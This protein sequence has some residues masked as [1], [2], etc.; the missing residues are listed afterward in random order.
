MSLRR[1][2]AAAA[3]VVAVAA[4]YWPVRGYPFVNFDD[5]I[6]VYE[7]PHVLGGLTAENALWA[8][9]GFHA[10]FWHP[11]IWWSLM[12]DCTLFG[13]GPAGFHA[14]NVVLHAANAVLLWLALS[15]MTGA[16][17]RSFAVAAVWALHPLRV[18]SVAWI[19]ERKDTLS[20]LFFL[21]TLLAYARYAARPG[22]TR[23]A[24]V[25]GAFALG[26]MAKP[27]L[28]TLPA[29][30]LM[31]DVWPLRRWRS[32]R[33]A[34]PLILE[35]GP[36]LALAVAA[37]GAAFIA[38]DTGGALPAL[39]A[40]SWPLRVSTALRA[41]VK[42]LADSLWPSHLC[43]FYPYDKHP[44]LP[45]TLGALGLLV[46]LT[47]GALW[48][49]RKQ[50]YLACGWGWF[51]VSLLPVCGIVQVGGFAAA[52]RFT[53]LPAIGLII[54]LVWLAADFLPKG[55]AVIAAAVCL[56]LAGA[57]SRQVTA[58]RSSRA[59]FDHALAADAGNWLA[60]YNVGE[61]DLTAGNLR[62]AQAHFREAVRLKPNHGESHDA[63]AY[64]LRATGDGEGAIREY[65]AATRDEPAR[66]TIRYNLGAALSE[67]GRLESA[68]LAFRCACR[69]DL[70]LAVAY[71]ALGNTLLALDQAADAIPEYETALRLDP[72]NSRV[73]ANLQIAR[74]RDKTPD[75][76]Y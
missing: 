54:A 67:G 52:D 47:L 18:E 41:P 12:L 40:I 3:L 33:D 2:L 27:M 44:D 20:G 65:L 10:N 48:R 7:N 25:L 70:H 55:K 36:P 49:L 22:R 63:L 53:Y 46:L 35:K 24:L 38:Q 17:G 26:L 28:V 9:N 62:L 19:T 29:V 8:A 14:V 60:H 58:W 71:E 32:F 74:E 64:T 72:G 51:C 75:L 37:A 43:I 69:L 15:R 39:D 16:D 61:A 45:A 31:L 76:R 5:N 73:P 50:P 34:A 30:L 23:Y 13:P 42:Y 11:L 59:L 66:A 57:S 21:L 1:F 4:V 6:Y 56:A 68:A